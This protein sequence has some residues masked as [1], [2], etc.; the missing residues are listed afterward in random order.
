M[1]SVDIGSSPCTDRLHVL[2]V[3][4]CAA[5]CYGDCD[6]EWTFI[7][8]FGFKQL[9]A[10]S[11]SSSNWDIDHR[12]RPHTSTGD[13]DHRHRPETSN[14]IHS[15]SS[16]GTIMCIAHQSTIPMTMYNHVYLKYNVKNLNSLYIKIMSN[17]ND[18]CFP[19]CLRLFWT[20][21][22]Y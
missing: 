5:R 9:N 1:W 2:S 14:R 18:Q 8:Y 21:Y 22:C 20:I 19:Q 10:T 15:W 11:A 3:L 4:W 16:Q 7:W 13:I 17:M 6:V 12:H